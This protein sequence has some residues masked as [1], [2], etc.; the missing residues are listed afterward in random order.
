MSQKT[1]RVPDSVIGKT[2]EDF[3]K[4]CLDKPIDQLP[5]RALAYL[6]VMHGKKCGVINQEMAKYALVVY[7]SKEK[8]CFVTKSHKGVKSAR[9]DPKRVKS[10]IPN[11]RRAQAR[12]GGV[13]LRKLLERERDI[14]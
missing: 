3:A 14:F 7:A 10:V 6:L 9:V 1:S 4:A 11:V 8:G 12:H 13:P 2:A 5:P